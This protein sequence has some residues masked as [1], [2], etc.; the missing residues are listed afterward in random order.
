MKAK[1]FYLLA[2][3]ALLLG[4]CVP[5]PSAVTTAVSAA[6]AQPPQPGAPV[7]LVPASAP[8]TSA[9]AATTQQAKPPASAP[10]ATAATTRQEKQ[11][12]GAPN[13]GAPNAAGAPPAEALAACQGK[14][15]QATCEF[16][17]EK[18]TEKGVCETV[19]GQLACSPQRDGQLGQGAG[20]PGGQA[21]GQVPAK[22]PGSAPDTNA[23][24][25][26]AYNIEQAISDKA[27]RSAAR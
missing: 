6:R 14:S 21:G 19:Q 13:A 18:G 9:T 7:Q 25:S 2:A 16:T 1:M 4:A 23:A 24:G 11:N 12:A 27:Q 22:A 26:P 20:Q 15:E 3:G 8:E 17:W 10:N 5:I